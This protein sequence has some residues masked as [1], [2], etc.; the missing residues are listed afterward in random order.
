[1]CVQSAFTEG[2]ESGDKAEARA[3][4]LMALTDD[5]LKPM[6][7]EFGIEGLPQEEQAAT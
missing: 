5:K 2:K 7:L 1:V 4:E 3:M 6:A